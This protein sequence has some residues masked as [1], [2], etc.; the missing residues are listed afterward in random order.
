VTD[1]IEPRSVQQGLRIGLELTAELDLDAVLQRG[2]AAARE[3]AGAD[4]AAVVLWNHRLASVEAIACEGPAPRDSALQRAAARLLP[5]W[6][7]RGPIVGRLA[8]TAAFTAWPVAARATPYGALFTPDSAPP[9]GHWP[10]TVE[11]LAATLG[12]AVRNARLVRSLRELNEFRDAMLQMAAHDLRAPLSHVVA[13][14]ELLREDVTATSEQREAWFDV[15][16]QALERMERLINAIL[17]YTRAGTEAHLRRDRVDM[18]A[19]AAAAAAALAPAALA[20]EQK[21]LL[22]GESGTAYTRGDAPLLAE[23]LRNVIANAITYSPRGTRIAVTV[24]VEEA[25]VS[26]SVA[27]NGPGIPVAEQPLLF[28][29]FRRLSTSAGTEGTGLGLSLVKRVVE[30]H[31][32]RI[33]VHS[34]P[35]EGSDFRLVLPAGHAA[36]PD[37]ANP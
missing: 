8:K 5:Q 14:L 31:G 28:Q 19:L 25:A 27:D 29:P 20:K 6:D 33:E 22:E 11:D 16:Q 9:P 4:W 36:A 17:D 21:L 32:G 3:L 2:A 12:V 15:T 26:V 10:N 23:A 7:W 24:R 37:G 13:Y 30:R 34:R 1:A 18:R 35:G